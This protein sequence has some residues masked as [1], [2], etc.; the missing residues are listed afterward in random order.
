MPY[1]CRAASA[2]RSA[3]IS[4][5]RAGHAEAP[6]RL[7]Q[8]IL[9]ICSPPP[10]S[11]TRRPRRSGSGDLETEDR[12]GPRHPRGTRR[13]DQGQRDLDPG[14]LRQ[15]GARPRL[16]GVLRRPP[17]SASSRSSTPSYAGAIPRLAA[18]VGSEPL[19]TWK[20]WLTF[21]QINQNTSVLP[22]KSFDQLSFAF[23]GNEGDR[24][25]EQQRP[26]D[27]RAIGAST[28]TSATRSASSTPTNISRPR[29]R[30][31]SRRW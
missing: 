26:R 28:P 5:H 29:P 27:K 9:P 30:P 16:E 25:A 17:S 13:L 3:N 24:H 21:H 31:R 8:D 20:D 1:L 11:P 23:N 2:C 19:D 7:P 6:G 22:S 12:P 14:R 4:V 10:A 15:K 18:L